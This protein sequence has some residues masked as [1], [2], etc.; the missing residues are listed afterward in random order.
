MGWLVGRRLI[1][2][3]GDSLSL[4]RLALV[5]GLYP[6]LIGLSRSLTPIMAIGGLNSLLTP[7]YSLSN[8]NVWLKILPTDR[9]EDA[10]AIYYTILNFGPFVF[11]LLGVALATRFGIP[12]T[13]IGCGLVVLLGSASFSIWPVKEPAEI[14]LA[15]SS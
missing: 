7:G 1:K 12:P 9:R 15:T 2:A 10:T 4:R 3:W 6:I 14:K 8:Y 5:I 11:P 13:L